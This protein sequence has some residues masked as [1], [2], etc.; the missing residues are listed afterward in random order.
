MHSFGK[1]LINTTNERGGGEKEKKSFVHYQ[2]NID[3]YVHH[4]GFCR[5]D[6][7][8]GVDGENQQ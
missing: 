2:I 8:G 5:T 3:M 4:E 6:G 7:W 1:T